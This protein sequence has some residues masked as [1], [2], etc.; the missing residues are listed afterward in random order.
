MALVPLPFVGAPHASGELMGAAVL[1][2]NTL[3]REERE[4]F[5]R[6]EPGAA[7]FIRPFMSGGD[8]IDGVERYCLWLVNADPNKLRPARSNETH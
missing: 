3:T 8:F 7:E 2:P 1:L 5:V 6:R 4:E